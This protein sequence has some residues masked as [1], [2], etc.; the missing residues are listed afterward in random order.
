MDMGTAGFRTN[1]S[2]AVLRR[3]A[4]LRWWGSVFSLA[5]ILALAVGRASAEAPAPPKYTC[6]MEL[7]RACTVTEE[8]AFCVINA[9]ES[10]DDCKENGGFWNDVGCY[11]LYAADF[12]ACYLTTPINVFLK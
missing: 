11:P 9:F 8:L 5:L 7:G 3:R 4:Q 2:L 1:A 10:Y 12:Y 6:D